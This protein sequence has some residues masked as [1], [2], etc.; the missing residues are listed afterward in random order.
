MTTELSPEMADFFI[1]LSVTGMTE[2][3]FGHRA[4]LSAATLRRWRNG[5]PPEG[6]RL[7]TAVA[8]V[9]QVLREKRDRI[10]EL[11]NAD[12]GVSAHGE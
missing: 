6:N 1:R 2:P 10:D 7:G 3:E 5:R 8:A 12:K 11:L 4:N 9:N